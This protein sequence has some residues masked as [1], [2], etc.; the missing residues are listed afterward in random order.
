MR[1]RLASVSLQVMDQGAPPRGIYNKRLGER[2]ATLKNLEQRRLR[3]GNVRLLVFLAAGASG[4]YAWQ[5]RIS[6][7]WILA[8]LAFYIAL[9]W[10]QS[11]I[12]RRAEF[13]RRGIRFYERGIA[14]V[15]NKWHGHG[16]SGERFLDPHHPYSVDLDIFGKGSLFE[17]LSTARTR[18]GEARLADWLKAPSSHD[19]LRQRHA[20]VDELRPLLDLREQLA[21]LGDDYRTGVNPENLIAWA[22][23]PP[24]PFAGWMR[25]LALAFAIV[26]AALLVWWGGSKLADLQVQALRAEIGFVLVG[27]AELALSLNIRRRIL[28]VL[29][30]IHEPF[31]RSGF[32]FAD[33]E[34]AGTAG[35]PVCSPRRASCG[36]QCG[37]KAGFTTYSGAPPPDGAARFARQRLCTDLRAPADVGNTTRNGGRELAFC[38]GAPCGAV[39]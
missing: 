33:S 38:A 19:E 11:R 14:R 25:N 21:V 39:A 22:N 5:G 8:P 18:G 34:H 29:H 9:V 37:R 6:G 12:E 23:E 26:Q 1:N 17:L 2:Q 13:A 24:R 20:A 28:S 16:E 15:E 35:V 31:P 4:W 36:Y 32:A 27:F 10:V 7:A 30:S 3:L